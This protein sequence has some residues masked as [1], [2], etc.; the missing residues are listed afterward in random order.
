METFMNNFSIFF[1]KIFESVQNLWNWYIST[2][3]GQVTIFILII[4]LFYF[5]IN[6]IIDF[7]D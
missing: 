1:S 2:I 7:K 4:T 6:L 5:L 3:I